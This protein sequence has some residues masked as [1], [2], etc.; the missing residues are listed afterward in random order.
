MTKQ[1]LRHR[2]ENQDFFLDAE[3]VP[4]HSFGD[5]RDHVLAFART[6]ADRILVIVASRFFIRL[7]CRT[8]APMGDEVWQ[9]SAVVIP[10]DRAS[11]KLTDVLTGRVLTPT[12]YRRRTLLPLSEAFADLPVAVFIANAED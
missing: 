3:Y 1:L 4:L 12:I 8:R 9:D 5:Q 11:L 7:G 6:T 10:N 2:L